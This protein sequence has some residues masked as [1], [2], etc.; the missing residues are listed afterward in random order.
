MI[1]LASGVFKSNKGTLGTYVPTPKNI[2]F[3]TQQFNNG[4]WQKLNGST[5]TADQA[6][7]PDGTTTAD[8]ATAGNALYG[9]LFCS[10]IS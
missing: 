10:E 4:Y 5:I 3:H 6:V 9:S 8:L 7:A 1:R 2:L